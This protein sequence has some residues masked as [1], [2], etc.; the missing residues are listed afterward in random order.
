MILINGEL[1][2]L[3][4]ALDVVRRHYGVTGRLVFSSERS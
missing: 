4:Q 3:A 2:T 1:C